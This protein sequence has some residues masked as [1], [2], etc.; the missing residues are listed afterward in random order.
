VHLILALGLGL[1]VSLALA[2]GLS[3]A[4]GGYIV[5]GYIALNL[6]HP[7]RVAATIGVAAVTLVVMRIVGRYTILFGMRRFVLFLLTGFALGTLFSLSIAN[8]ARDPIEAIG[9]LV[10]GLIA[11]WMDRQG[12]AVTLGSMLTA[13]VV[14]RLAILALGVA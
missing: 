3:I 1:V 12:A 10:P 11:S 7:A 8:G 9:F 13:A 4:P 14:A 5:P 2:E 6:N